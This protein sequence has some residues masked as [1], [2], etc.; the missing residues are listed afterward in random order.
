MMTGI[1]SAVYWHLP[2]LVFVAS[3]VY[4]A[5][6]YDE[7]DR[8]LSH[9]V[10]MGLYLIFVFMGAVFLILWLMASVFPKIF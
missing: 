8:I 3:M 9:G 6:R 4:N 10:K 1:P 2:I 7:W 5:T